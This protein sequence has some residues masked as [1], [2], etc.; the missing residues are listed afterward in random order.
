MPCNCGQCPPN[1][2]QPQQPQGPIQMSTGYGPPPLVV[3]PEQNQFSAHG[4][5]LCYEEVFAV[6]AEARRTGFSIVSQ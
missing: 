1:Q 2:Q 6:I 4:Y 3:S 5:S